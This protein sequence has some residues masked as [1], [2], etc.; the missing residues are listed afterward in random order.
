MEVMQCESAYKR[1]DMEEPKDEE[2]QNY[3][4]RK[5]IFVDGDYLVM[6]TTR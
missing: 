4:A 2:K 6:T 1:N 5:N 3:E